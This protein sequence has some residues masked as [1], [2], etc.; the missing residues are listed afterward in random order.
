MQRLWVLIVIVTSLVSMASPRAW[1]DPPRLSFIPFKRIDA[2]PNKK[3]QLTEANGPWLIMASSFVGPN[4]EKQSHEL[5]MELRSQFKLPAYV[6]KHHFDFSQRVE[7]LGLNRKGKVKIMKHASGQAF[8]EF[9]VLVGNYDSIEDPNA[10][11]ALHKLKH[12]DPKCLKLTQD[13]GASHR[14]GDLRDYYKLV[15]LELGKQDVKGP[16]GNAFVV[17]NP[18]IPED[19]YTAGIDPFVLKMNEKIQYS[20]L[21]IPGK[22]S[23]KVATFTGYSTNRL[24]EIEKAK[25]NKTTK[26]EEAGE[27][28]HTLTLALRE[29]GVEA[30]E[31]HDRHESM[32]TIGSFDS[33]GEPRADGKTEINPSIHRLMEMYGAKRQSL[34]GQPAVGL[35]PR[36]LKSIPFD[37]Q[38]MPVQVP[39]ASLGAKYARDRNE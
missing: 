34:P 33:I 6:H 3:Y 13:E 7:G 11:K 12:A 36:T 29:Q 38:P 18:L 1:A 14:F 27:K 24:D 15:Q 35:M 21:K 28:A 25:K 8:D 5:V 37:V 2:D 16:M 10:D 19:Y 31:F 26:L 17:R 39:K 4:A 20:A 23:V 22:Y 32:V 9:A 30:F